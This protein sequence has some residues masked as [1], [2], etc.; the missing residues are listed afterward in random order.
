MDDAAWSDH[1]LHSQAFG[2]EGGMYYAQDFRLTKESYLALTLIQIALSGGVIFGWQAL[3]PVLYEKGVYA[4]SCDGG[5]EDPTYPCLAMRNK[6]A[7]V[8]NVACACNA[9]GALVAGFMMDICGTRV[10]RMAS[11]LMVCLGALMIAWAE[12]ESILWF[13]GLACIGFGGNGLQITSFHISN[14]F[15]GNER[16]IVSTITGSFAASASLFTIMRLLHDKM[17]WDLKDQFLVYAALT[18]MVVLTSSV[19]PE[20]PFSCIEDLEP[21][22]AEESR[23]SA[24]R[25]RKGDSSVHSAMSAGAMSCDS[26]TEASHWSD[27]S[28]HSRRDSLGAEA[29][30]EY[31]WADEDFHRRSLFPRMRNNSNDSEVWEPLLGDLDVIPEVP[32]ESTNQLC[33]DLSGYTLSEQLRSPE[34]AGLL[35][36]FL[37]QLLTSTYYLTGVGDQLECWACGCA[38]NCI[39]CVPQCSDENKKKGDDWLTIFGV[40]YP[41]GFIT[42]PL[43]GYLQDRYHLSWLMIFV[44]FTFVAWQVC[45]IIPSIH[46]QAATL[47]IFSSAR[48]FLFS[49][50]FAGVGSTFGYDNFG[51]LTGLANGISAFVLLL[52]A[53]I[54]A[55]TA[56]AFT[57]TY[58]IMAGVSMLFFVIALYLRRRFYRISQQQ[59]MG[60][61]YDT[62]THASTMSSPMPPMRGVVSGS[63]LLATAAHPH[64]DVNPAEAIR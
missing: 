59:E 1:G 43:C 19:W 52:N 56:P 45:A 5:T 11:G 21:W 29:A 28:G 17:E 38:G 7:L 22:R 30:S 39:E 14:L 35:F 42:T 51:F 60:L 58:S 40:V 9:G 47:V 32:L 48:Q 34:W 46:A 27:A 36:F 63:P 62:S 26:S 61:D 44:N 50:F 53:P 37:V 12:P 13:P 18:G 55:H 31:A 10:A 54:Y 2:L 41:F 8:F 4:E 15:L 24:K 33:L 49:F 16:L 6:L 25:R 64:T 23:H 20:K 3:L 57:E